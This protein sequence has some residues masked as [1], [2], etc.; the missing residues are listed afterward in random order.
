MGFQPG[1]GFPRSLNEAQVGAG[2]LTRRMCVSQ[3]SPAKELFVSPRALQRTLLYGADFDQA[4]F[5][6]EM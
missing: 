1:R 2:S 6:E 3:T 4:R 5:E